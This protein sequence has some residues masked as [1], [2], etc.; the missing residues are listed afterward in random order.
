MDQRPVLSCCRKGR[1]KT[2]RVIRYQHERKTGSAAGKV[3]G[4]CEPIGVPALVSHRH[5]V[6]DEVLAHTLDDRLPHLR[7][8]GSNLIIRPGVGDLHH[9]PGRVVEGFLVPEHDKLLADRDRSLACADRDRPHRRSGHSSKKRLRLG[10]YVG[11]GLDIRLS[12]GKFHGKGQTGRVTALFAVRLREV[13]IDI[14]R[15]HRHRFQASSTF[16]SLSTVSG[17]RTQ[18]IEAPATKAE[19][20]V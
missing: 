10:V 14:K 1:L 6:E 9:D 18:T 16:L 2:W 4:L 15:F 13:L 11:A 5:T 17:W 19:Y 3:H 8:H 7:H 20:A 12:D